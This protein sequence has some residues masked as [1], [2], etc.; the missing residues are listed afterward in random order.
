MSDIAR[1]TL[2]LL[3]GHDKRAASGHPWVYSNEI[4]MDAAAKALP[5]GSLVALSTANG[6]SLGTATF[7]PHTL[8]AARFL[9]RDAAVHVDRGFFATRLERALA[10][11]H[12][13]YPEPYYRLIHAEADGLPGIILD[14]FGDVLSAQI[15]TA[16]MMLLEEDFLAACREVLNPRAI[17]LRNDTAARS[18][19]GL[20]GEDRVGF[21][22][23][24]PPVEL[25]ENGARFAIDPLGGQ[26]TGWFYDQRENRRLASRFAGGRVLDL[27]CFGGGFGTL[28]ALAGADQ[29]L[30]V[31]RSDTALKLAARSA[32][33]NGVAARCRF[34]KAEAFEEL[35]RLHG[36]GERFDLVIADPP[37]FARSKKDLGPA[38][39][40]YRKLARLSA[41]LVAKGGTL[42]IASCSHHVET[43][44]FA[45]SV[46][47]GLQDAQRD[48]RIIATTGA[49]PD[50]PVHP[51][52]PESAYLKAQLVALD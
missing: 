51:F 49:A 48:G 4:Q 25:I 31:D 9:S 45:D 7:N 35:E 46:R 52:L 2:R 14:R 28:A 11:R 19:E 13:L 16:G 27:Y 29:V 8:I 50:H 3:P 26:K 6:K 12:R 43:E 22:E 42:F 34:A 18:L 37:A 33:L 30:A 40:G 36:Q 38:L 39:R 44:A 20:A 41:S 23:L 24:A 17:V 10:L 15:N 1:P 32:E 21:G 5:P 47:R